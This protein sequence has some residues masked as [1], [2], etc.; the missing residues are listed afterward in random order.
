[1]RRV[2]FSCAQAEIRD[3]I[4]VYYGVADTV[5]GVAEISK[6]KIKFD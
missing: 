2:V 1:M 4:S 5:I 6:K 3:K